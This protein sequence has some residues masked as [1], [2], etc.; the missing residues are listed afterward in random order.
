MQREIPHITKIHEALWSIA[1]W[2]VEMIENDSGM[3]NVPTNFHEAKVYSSSRNKFYLVQYDS[4][5]KEIMSNDNLSYRKWMIWY[6]SICLLML[7]WELPYEKNYANALRGIKWKDIN[8]EFK[9]DFDKTLVY[10]ENIMEERWVNMD[11]FG[12]YKKEIMDKLKEL[13]LNYL[14]KKRI[15]P[16]AY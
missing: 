9:N 10:A 15:P 12:N 16:K 6:P 4:D 14:W 13:S 8:T 5:K 2:R 11:Q 3:F 7:V 1:D